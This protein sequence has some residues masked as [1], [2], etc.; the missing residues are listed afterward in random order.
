[1]SGE[2]GELG[3]I[4]KR[5]V[6]GRRIITKRAAGCPGP[7]GFYRLHLSLKSFDEYALK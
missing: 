2:K 7:K 1:L 5:G 4:G 6:Q 3:E